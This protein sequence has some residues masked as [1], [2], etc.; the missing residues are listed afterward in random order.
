MNTSPDWNVRQ[1]RTKEMKQP[2]RSINKENCDSSRLSG[3]S[4]MEAAVLAVSTPLIA[5]DDSFN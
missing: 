4:D 1:P 2:P 5:K 3:M